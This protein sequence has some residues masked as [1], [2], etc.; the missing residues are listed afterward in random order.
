MQTG[1]PEYNIS[2][3]SITHVSVLSDRIPL[4]RE[5]KIEGAVAIFRNRTEVTK[6]AQDLTGIQ[7]IVEALR[8]Y[9]HEFTN[10][11]HVILGLIQL[12]ENQRAEEYILRITASEAQSIDYI[13]ERIQDPHRGRPAGGQGLPGCGAGHPFTLTPASTLHGDN[14]YL[15]AMGMITVLGNLIENA[16]DALL[17][18]AWG[19][20]EVTVSI[21]EG[22]HG[23]VISVDDTGPGMTEEVRAHIFD[24]GFSTKGG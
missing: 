6:L 1:K 17:A 9:T 24:K 12:G 19:A 22:Q 5:G 16:F 7:H 20:S 13:R 3:E 2:L 4:W 10:K 14:P 15:P 8:T 21:R 18:P 11:L 23:L